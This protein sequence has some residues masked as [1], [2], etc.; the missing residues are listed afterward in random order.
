MGYPVSSAK[1]I[2]ENPQLKAREV[3]Q[4][5]EHPELG[6]TI[7]YPGP[8]A[9]F[10]EAAVGIRRRAPLIGE[11]NRE[12]YVNELGMSNIELVLLKQGNII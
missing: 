4:E 10:S 7:T 11:H 5:I 9:K 2:M 12:I 3:W 6:G 8:W 1:D